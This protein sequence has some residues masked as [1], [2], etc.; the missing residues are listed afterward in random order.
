MVKILYLPSLTRDKPRAFMNGIIVIMYLTF[1]FTTYATKLPNKTLKKLT[2]NNFSPN[3]SEEKQ[4]ATRKINVLVEWCDPIFC[5]TLTSINK[6]VI[7]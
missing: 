3:L 6:L 2:N 7:N 4:T 1:R 5:N